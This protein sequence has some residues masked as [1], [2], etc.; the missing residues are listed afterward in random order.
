MK[1]FTYLRKVATL[2]LDQGKCIGCEMCTDVCPHQ[3]FSMVDKT[4][5]IVELDACMECGACS[6]NCPVTAI[7]VDTG[8][9]C[10]SGMINEWLREHNIGGSIGDCCT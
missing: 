7:H 9:G 8:V 1:G 10:A 2:K 4:A 6:I 5:T 3:V